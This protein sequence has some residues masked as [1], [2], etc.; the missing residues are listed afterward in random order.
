MTILVSA[1]TARARSASL[2]RNHFGT[3]ITHCR[4]A[5]GGMT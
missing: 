2:P 3:E 1:A 5:T 4:T